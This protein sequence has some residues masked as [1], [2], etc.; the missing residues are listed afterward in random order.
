MSSETFALGT[1]S[2]HMEQVMANITA[3][4]RRYP[5]ADITIAAQVAVWL[6]QGISSG[7]IK[8]KFPFSARD[9]QL[10]RGFLR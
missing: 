1:P 5:N 2:P 3:Y 7:K 4:A 6:V 8:E 10:A 9:E